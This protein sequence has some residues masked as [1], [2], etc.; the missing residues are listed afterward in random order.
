LSGRI[1]NWDGHDALAHHRR[2]NYALPFLR[3]LGFASNGMRYAFD[4]IRADGDS[5][6]MPVRAAAG[7]TVVRVMADQPD[8][9]SFDPQRSLA[10]INALFGNYIVIDHG[11]GVFSL[12]GHL[13]Q[14][15]VRVAAG[16]RVRTGQEIAAVG[17]SGSAEFP[18]LHFQLM[19]APDMHGE[20]IPSLFRDFSRVRGA[21]RLHVREGAVATG[22]TVEAR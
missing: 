3:G 21:S 7:G 13:R 17:N 15:S 10:D 22:E 8:D 19:D 18:H 1:R 12:Y 2:W 6:G 9:R 20:G 5:F 14:H 16:E 4:F 11:N